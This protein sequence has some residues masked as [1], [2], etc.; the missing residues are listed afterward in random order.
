MSDKLSALFTDAFNRLVHVLFFSGK[1]ELLACL[2]AI[3]GVMALL[4][5]VGRVPLSYNEEER[6][7]EH[8]SELQ[9]LRH[10]V[11]SLMI[12]KKKKHRKNKRHQD[13]DAY[14]IVYKI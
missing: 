2:G 1:V 12:E 13:N 7:E 3:L 6:S 14:V 11:C 9:S 8:T 10:I 4:F 5:V